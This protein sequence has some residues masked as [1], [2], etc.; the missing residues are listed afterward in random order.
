MADQKLS[1]PDP[2]EAARKIKGFDPTKMNRFREVVRR[3]SRK[4][5]SQ[6]DQKELQAWLAEYPEL[7]SSIFDLAELTRV[8]LIQ[9]MV[10]GDAARTALEANVASIR[11]GFGYD[12]APMIEKLLID[13]ILIAWLRVQWLESQLTAFM[14]SGDL[15]ASVVEFW[16]RRL[17]VSQRRYLAACQTL[18]KIRELSSRNPRLQLNIATEGGQQVNIAGD[19]VKKG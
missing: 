9:H 1:L 6:A 16:E 13:N 12:S 7:L 14:E 15:N 10:A 19:V 2:Y 3:T 8:E 4:N 18:A 11:E 5:P 17:S